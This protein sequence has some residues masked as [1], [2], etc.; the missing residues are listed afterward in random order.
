M[1]TYYYQVRDGGGL[2]PTTW[3]DYCFIL[4]L[5]STL[6]TQGTVSFGILEICYSWIPSCHVGSILPHLSVVYSLSFSSC[7]PDAFFHSPGSPQSLLLVPL[8]EGSHLC[9]W[10]WQLLP[11]Q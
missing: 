4:T 1:S 8:D 6:P 5:S 11:P 9:K 3:I 7:I 10:A 2:H